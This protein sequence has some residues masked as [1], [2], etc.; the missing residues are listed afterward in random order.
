MGPNALLLPL[1]LTVSLNIS[2][3]RQMTVCQLPFAR[4]ILFTGQS[5]ALSQ[6]RQ[7]LAVVELQTARRSASSHSPSYI[8]FLF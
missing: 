4:T 8:E 1:P 3:P 7:P 2:P 5:A 6:Q